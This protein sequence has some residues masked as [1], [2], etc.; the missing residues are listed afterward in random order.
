MVGLCPGL[1]ILFSESLMR[2]HAEKMNHLFG[3]M[4]RSL[5]EAQK[6]D[7]D[8]SNSGHESTDVTDDITAIESDISLNVHLSALEKCLT[9][10]NE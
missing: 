10:P 2:N 7:E 4:A 6:I 1:L 8:Q 3:G 5:R 9:F